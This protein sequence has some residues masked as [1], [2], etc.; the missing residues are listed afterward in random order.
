MYIHMYISRGFIVNT[1]R[2]L[3]RAFM[4]GSH[5]GATV[6]ILARDAR[7][8]QHHCGTDFDERVTRCFWSCSSFQSPRAVKLMMR[9]AETHTQVALPRNAHTGSRTQ[10]TSM[11]GLYD[12]ATLRALLES[13]RSGYYQ[14]DIVFVHV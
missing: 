14:A 4:T 1:R 5:V 12:A 6:R 10:V 7:L 11:G 9:V 2:K 8:A 13:L 3:P